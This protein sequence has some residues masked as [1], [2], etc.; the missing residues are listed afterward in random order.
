MPD[1]HA[2]RMTTVAAD[3]AT[4][5][6][7]GSATDA[8]MGAV[9]AGDHE[10]ASH[11]H[12]P[13][14]PRAHAHSG[15]THGPLSLAD[16]HDHE[17]QTYDAMAED[18]LANW[19]DADYAVDPA[20]LPFA[21]REHVDFL[22]AAVARLGPLAGRRVLEVG[23]GGGSL[24]VWLALQGAQVVGIDVSAG[25]L[26]VAERRAAVNGVADR[27]HLV[28]SPVENFDPAEHGL[29][30][31]GFDAIIG[32]N[33]VHHF[34][35]ELALANLGRLLRPGAVAVF[36]EPVLFLPEW[37]RRVRNSAWVTRRFPM[38]THSPDERSLGTEDITAMRRW[39][40]HV[41]LTPFQL[42]CRL[43]NFVE[44]SDPAWRRL[45]SVDR[46]LLQRIPTTRRLC[47]FVVVTLA[48]PT[49]GV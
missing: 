9:P 3:S 48:L 10:H 1:L 41:D 20:R 42:L 29:A 13:G 39:F 19:R 21:N 44:L 15:A 25:I 30:T 11:R 34:D 38:H 28:H 4:D 2:H 12:H 26:Q 32:N 36:C 33:V 46:I 37:T 31:G 49:E 47:R 6:T 7:T 40:R 18:L 27:V 5:V 16:R 35:R 24:A 23:V 8:P 17:A 14:D 43:Q 22:T 45:E